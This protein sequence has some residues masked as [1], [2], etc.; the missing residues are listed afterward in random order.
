MPRTLI[1]A[2]LLLGLLGG[3]CSGGGHGPASDS[4]ASAAGCRAPFQ[5]RLDPRSTQH[6]FPGAAEPAYLSDPPTSGPHRLG[7]PP[8]GLVSTPISRPV[9]VAML[10]LGYVV[11][12]YRPSGGGEPAGPAAAV[13]ALAGDLVT[14]APGPSQP[15]LP[16]PVVATAW[17]W[18]LECGSSPD[19]GALTAFIA[20]HRGQ[21]FSHAGGPTVTSV[22]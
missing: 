17:T 3:A 16:A 15:R 20:A 8:T 12:Q 2:A 21:G 18:K 9:Q 5:E 10:E 7:P 11:V 19:A 14:V 6:L 4:S 1:V 13:A 22:K